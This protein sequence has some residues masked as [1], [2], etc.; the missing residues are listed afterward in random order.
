MSELKRSSDV[1]ET[2]AQQMLM[3]GIG[4]VVA[5]GFGLVLLS[6][7]SMAVGLAWVLILAGA[8]GIGYAIY[9]AVQMRKVPGVSVT[10]PYCTTS[11]RL[12]E[13]PT[14]DFRCTSCH[15]LVPVENGKILEVFQVRCGFCNHLNYYSSKSEGL[16]CEDC[17]REVPIAVGSG[18]VGN[19]MFAAYARRDDDGQYELLLSGYGH[20]PTKN[21]ELVNC[22]Q[23]MLAL[24]RN[25]VKDLMTSLPAVLLTGIPKKKA[26]MLAAQLSLHEGLAEIRPLS[27]SQT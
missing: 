18:E 8:G 6:Y 19:K 27:G 3:F 14:E 17:N 21:E 7:F 25:Q 9:H 12:V 23:H 13:P 1:M 10:C 4:G 24:N 2:H 11:N 15:R 26:E 22:L 16:L 5:V 20:N